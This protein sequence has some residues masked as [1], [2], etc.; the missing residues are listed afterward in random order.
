MILKSFIST[1]YLLKT[2]LIVSLFI[3]SQI[4]YG[5]VGPPVLTCVENF[6]GDVTLQWEIPNDPDSEFVSYDIYYTNDDFATET[7]VATINSYG[8]GIYNHIGADATSSQVCYYMITNSNNGTP[9]VSEISNRL[10]SVFIEVI[11]ALSPL[12]HAQINIES[13][14]QY[15]DD[16]D[17]PVGSTYSVF[18]DPLGSIEQIGLISTDLDVFQYEVVDCSAYYEF[19]VMLNN[20]GDCISFSNIAG[21]FFEDIT[22]PNAPIMNSISIDSTNLVVN[23]NWEIPDAVDVDGYIVYQCFTAGNCS[24]HAPGIFPIDT[25][26]GVAS[27]YSPSFPEICIGLESQSWTIAAFD[28]CH[29]DTII[30]GIGTIDFQ[31]GL[32][33]G[34]P[35]HH[36]TYLSNPIWFPC[37]EEVILNWSPYIGWDNLGGV[38]YYEVY[39]SENGQNMQPWNVLNGT[40]FTDTVVVNPGSSYRFYIKGTSFDGLTTISNIQTQS[41]SSLGSPNFTHLASVSVLPADENIEVLIKIDTTLEDHEYVL[42]KREELDDVFLQ[43]ASIINASDPYMTYVDTDVETNKFTYEYRVFVVNSCGDTIIASNAARSIKL[44]LTGDNNVFVNKLNWTSYSEFGL[45][46]NQYKIFRSEESG[47]IGNE[48]FSI[49]GNDNDYTDDLSSTISGD[50]NLAQGLYCYTIQAVE[51]AGNPYNHLGLSYSN[52]ECYQF[53]TEIFIPNAFMVEGFNEIFKPVISMA[54]FR[55]YNF[56]IFNRTGHVLFQTFDYETGWDGFLNGQQ[57]P[58][59]AYGYSLSVKDAKGQLYLRQGLMYK[60]SYFVR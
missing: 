36:S 23:L 39:Y 21:E 45:P 34:N 3:I 1:T 56:K 47:V 35:C 49:D 16:S 41:I 58:D 13:A 10:C 28:D 25:I 30:D 12:G 2:Y 8:V 22:S 57:V 27:S 37:G 40:T 11:H 18:F 59:G 33:T 6:D 20:G 29:V 15:Y 51:T 48:I 14:Y 17:I 9:Q 50:G 54:D 7:L 19:S 52:Q 44:N 46:V 43:I 55:S 32:S 26:Y 53:S 60:L 24:G 31:N 42:E 4:F 38:A 5:Q